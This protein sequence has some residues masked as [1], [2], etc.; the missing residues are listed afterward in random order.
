MG[1]TTWDVIDPKLGKGVRESVREFWMR[2]RYADDVERVEMLKPLAERLIGCSA[3]KD[4]E[5]AKH[6]VANL[7]NSYLE[8]MFN[9]LCRGWCIPPR[10]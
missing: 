6:C 3:I 4:E 2:W 1:M 5:L 10:E 9:V 8:D 7:L